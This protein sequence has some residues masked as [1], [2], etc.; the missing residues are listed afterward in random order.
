MPL[1]IAAPIYM[2]DFSGTTGIQ[3]EYGVSNLQQASTAAGLDP[4]PTY[5][6]DFLGLGC[7]TLNMYD[8][9]INV[10]NNSNNIFGGASANGSIY[11]KETGYLTTGYSTDGPI[12]YYDST[13]TW[14]AESTSTCARPASLGDAYDLE[15]VYVAGDLTT[16][17]VYLGPNNVELYMNVDPPFGTRKNI[18]SSAILG[19]DR[20]MNVNYFMGPIASYSWNLYFEARIYQAGTN[21][22]LGTS[23]HAIELSATIPVP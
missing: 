13:D 7:L 14:L 21:N 15:L 2:K 20:F 10:E 4:L 6:L 12:S 23:Q 11:W 19:V 3:D 9:P 16:G 17:T 1:P 22:L 18:G 5:M 8:V